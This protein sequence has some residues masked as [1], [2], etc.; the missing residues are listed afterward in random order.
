MSDY[1]D[2]AEVAKIVKLSEQTIYRRVKADT[3]PKPLKIS[4]K[5]LGLEPGR[6]P[7][8][9]NRWSRSELVAW[10]LKGNDPAWMSLPVKHLKAVCAEL[11]EVPIKREELAPELGP[12]LNG[13]FKDEQLPEEEAA[14]LH[15]FDP[16]RF[17]SEEAKTPPKTKRFL[18][19]AVIG[20]LLA[21]LFVLL[22]G[23]K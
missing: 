4:R 5:D 9:L 2:V 3:F 19:Q 11:D 23:G 17:L 6:G 21:G 1:I 10:L 13:L 15:E 12:R 7:Q 14:E 20:A 22:F 16:Y 8:K 18:A